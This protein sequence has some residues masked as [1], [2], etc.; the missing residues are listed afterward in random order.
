MEHPAVNFSGQQQALQ[1]SLGV[2]R[3]LW[4]SHR[5]RKAVKWLLA[6]WSI[7]GQGASHGIAVQQRPCYGG[8]ATPRDPNHAQ[9]CVLW[10]SSFVNKSEPQD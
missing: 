7:L 10:A 3:A 8:Q 4:S 2:G 6:S 1:S 9:F 5:V